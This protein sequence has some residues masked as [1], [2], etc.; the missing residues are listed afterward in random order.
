MNENLV[1]PFSR[2]TLFHRSFS[3]SLPKL[4]NDIP[5][6]IRKINLYFPLRKH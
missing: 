4:W 2:G 1:I 6:D 5:P 3:Y